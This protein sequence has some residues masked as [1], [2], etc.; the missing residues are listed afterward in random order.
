MSTRKSILR[1]IALI[2]LALLMSGQACTISL[3]QFP[4]LFPA[5]PTAQP[6]VVTPAG[7]SPTPQPMAQ[8]TFVAIL[9]EQLAAGETLFLIVLDEVTG[10][11]LNATYYQMQPRDAQTYTAT[12]PLPLNSVIKYRYMRRGSTQNTEDTALNV[13]IRYRL[14]SVLAQGETQDIIADWA[15]KSYNRATG[16]IQGR[17][18]N[19]DTNTPLP[20]MMVTAGGVQY[21]TDSGGRFSIQG[22]PA[23]THNLVGWELSTISAR[24]GSRAGTEHQCGSTR[25]ARADSGYYLHNLCPIEYGS[26]RARAFGR[27]PTSTG[28]HVRRPAGWREHERRTHASPCVYTRRTLHN[29]HQPACRCIHSI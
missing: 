7:P 23:G 26:R 20:N 17:V 4:D 22:L 18:L 25:K 28:Q 24:R 1:R 6:G 5:N 2:T 10:L 29:N 21:I 27:Q 3:I 14:Y 8:T 11:S 16:N 12:L 19:A 15:D 13:A 9:P